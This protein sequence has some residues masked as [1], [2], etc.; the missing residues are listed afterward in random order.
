MQALIRRAHDTAMGILRENAQKLNHLAGYLL[1]KESITGEEFM[2]IL[3]EAP[4][5]IEG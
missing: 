1:E 5:A 2:D 3:N 4:A